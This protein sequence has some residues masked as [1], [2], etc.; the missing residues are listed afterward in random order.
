MTTR[1]IK[2]DRK[3]KSLKD[4]LGQNVPLSVLLGVGCRVKTF[5]VRD[6]G[7]GCF[8]VELDRSS[9]VKESNE[10][11]PA[12]IEAGVSAYFDNCPSFSDPYDV[13]S[14]TLV[15]AIYLAMSSAEGC[16]SAESDQSPSQVR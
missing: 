3:T 8:S 10:V 6:H 13:D 5:S 4:A 2:N 11:T 14:N 12:M 9:S 1:G 16:A 7:F 15:K